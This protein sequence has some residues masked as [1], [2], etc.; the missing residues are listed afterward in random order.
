[1]KGSA[2]WP[3]KDR[4]HRSILYTILLLPRD[5]YHEI[6]MLCLSFEAAKISASICDVY[7]N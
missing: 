6:L 3:V 1:M 4:P 7:L 2:G 5:V